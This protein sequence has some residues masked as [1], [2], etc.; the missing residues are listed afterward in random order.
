MN[1]KD[2][3]MNMEIQKKWFLYIGD[4]HE[5]P[6]TVEEVQQK[7]IAGLV[8]DQSYAWCEG[9]ADW[10]VVAEIPTLHSELGKINET[11]LP[12]PK[13]EAPSAPKAKQVRPRGKFQFTPKMFGI[14]IGTAALLFILSLGTLIT[15]SR[16][17]SDDL[18]SS[19]RP[20]F[21]KVID[22]FPFLS[23]SFRLVPKLNDVK[24]E[25]LQELE[26]AQLGLPDI[27]VKLAI[28]LSQY[29]PIRPFF[30]I[31]TNLPTKTKLDLYL[32]GNSETLLNRLQF[33]TQTTISI[34]RGIGK[35]EVLSAEG[36]QPLPK[37]E[38]Q[39][40]ITESSDQETGLSALNDYPTTRA[41]GALPATVPNSTHY[42]FMKTVFIGGERDET[43]LTRL[44]AFHEKIKQNADRE[45]VELKQYSDTLF[46]QYTALTTDFE[47]LYRSKKSTSALRTAWK[48]TETTWHQINGQL[49]QTI[50]SWTKETLQNEYFYGKAYELIKSSFEAL[51]NLYTIE[52]GFVEQPRDHAAFD[53]ELGKA[54]SEAREATLLLRTKIDLIMKAPKTATGL[55]TREGL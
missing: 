52:S 17:A 6:F 27:G 30:Y 11:D 31:G 34:Y 14:A 1:G 46:L 55:P 40:F 24:P 26:Q 53:I 12:S 15:L 47:K 5:G 9:M 18:H 38:Y 8:T 3:K 51:K 44:K 22:T 43:Y 7:K 19:L 48:K 21:L 42:L 39:V 23:G 35:T 16:T 29:D 2:E 4:H 49:D 37:G 32:I 28:A 50:Q 41:A 45:I 33:S 13:A 20:T 54:T 10:Q 36:G 25:D